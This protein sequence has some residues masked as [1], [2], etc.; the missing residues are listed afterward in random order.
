MCDKVWGSSLVELIGLKFWMWCY[1]NKPVV[2]L[3]I[4]IAPQQKEK[5]K[6][7]L[8][9]WEMRFTIFRMG[10]CKYPFSTVKLT[11]WENAIFSPISFLSEYHSLCFD[12]H[13][14]VTD[15]SHVPCSS[16]FKLN[17]V[18]WNIA[19]IFSI[20]Y[21]LSMLDFEIKKHDNL[22]HHDFDHCQPVWF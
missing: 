13:L 5:K 3:I 9:W 8:V 16:C 2:L 22:L 4:V 17:H 11:K 10:T 20:H 15:I 18:E 7:L 19:S 1:K 12:V 14:W 21:M 6:L